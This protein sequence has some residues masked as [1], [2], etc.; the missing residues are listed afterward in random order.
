MSGFELVSPFTPSGDQPAAIAEIVAGLAAGKESQVLLGVTGSGKT[1]TIANVIM[2]TQ[3]PTLVLAPN[4]TLAAQLHAEFKSF[5]PNNAVEYFVSYYDYYQPEAYIASSD[6]YIEKDS[7][8]NEEIDRMRHAATFGLLERRDVIIVA[9]VSC[10]YGLGAPM[11]YVDM[12]LPLAVG[13]QIGRRDLLRA[14][15]DIQYERSDMDLSRGHFRARGDVIEVQP[16]AADDY[17]YR[18][19]MWG[20]E[21][22]AIDRIDPLRG[23]SDASVESVHIYPNSHF[24]TSA[25]TVARARGTIAMELRD[26]LQ[27]L[28]EEGKL[29]ERQRLEQ[30][31]MFDLEE[32]QSRSFC[33]GIENYSRHLTG[34]D[35][36]EPPPTLID[37]FPKDFL[38]VVDESH[39]MMPQVGAMYRGD[40]SRKQNLVQFGFRLPSA[41]DNRPLMFDEFRAR[42]GQS[43]YVSATP[44]NWELE[45]TEGEIIEQVVRPTGLLDPVIE[46]RPVGTQIDDLLGEIRLR[47][48][49]HERVLI[50]TLTKRMAENLTEYYA[51]LGVRV[52]YMH[53]DIET[54]ERIEL[55]RGLRAGDFDVLVGINLLREGLDLPE[56]SLVGI[57]DADKEGFLRSHRSLVQTIGRA[58]RN[59]EG[60]VI[61]YADRI[62]GS[63]R[64]AMDETDRRREI[65]AAYNV[66]HGITP[67]SI[68]KAITG[69]ETLQK[70]GGEQ[71][72]ADV[73]HITDLKE[74]QARI[75]G[76]RDEMKAAARSLEFE[77]AAALRDEVKHMQKLLLAV[78]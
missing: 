52:R 8:I 76:L 28:T 4:K 6:T 21:I 60:R 57:L 43:I 18:I 23:R 19:S 37:Y 58:S 64:S 78:S 45:Q 70:G 55:L 49:R 20:D 41:M 22:E 73:M 32:L 24:V 35:A 5:F 54:L 67:T 1:F 50:T 26:R 29:V 31:T 51:D 3:R 75:E 36:G 77:R 27:E 33:K 9:S 10:I 17:A 71:E 34:R 14:L 46:L 48:E 47:V 30:R 7:L 40:R 65:Q 68:R 56:V 69:I 39:V 74:L 72:A 16:A 25:E 15:V 66:A 44:G 61:L 53:S 63:M 13:Q 59:L 11:D 38:L 2:Q 62:T 12:R 42:I